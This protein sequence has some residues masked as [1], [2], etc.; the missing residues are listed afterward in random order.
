MRCGQNGARVKIVADTNTLVSGFLWDGTPAKF[1]S[2]AFTGRARLFTSAELLLELAET[3]QRP[4][5]AGRF[6]SRG[7]TPAGIFNRYRDA[8]VKIVPVKIIPP[9]NLRDADD[10]HVLAC[11]AAAEAGAIVTGDL[12]L[13]A[14]KSFHGI[15]IMTAAEI[16]QQLK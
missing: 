2:A 12:D 14:L 1:V 4:K 6:L 16:L 7:Q 9:K 10:V 11:A 3:L 8:S 15:P 5:F 13:L